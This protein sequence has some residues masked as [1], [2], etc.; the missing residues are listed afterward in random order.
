MQ[1]M[2]TSA[3]VGGKTAMSVL[4]A[5][6]SIAGTEMMPLQ[7]VGTKITLPIITSPTLP[8]DGNAINTSL[9]SQFSA[10]KI[11][12]DYGN[13]I[14]EIIQQQQSEQAS[15]VTSVGSNSKSSASLTQVSSSTALSSKMQQSSKSVVAEA[16]ESSTSVSCS[17]YSSTKKQEILSSSTRSLSSTESFQSIEKVLTSSTALIDD[18]EF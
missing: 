2:A 6:G 17:S 9:E 12:D 7:N 10:M 15:C 11:K 5:D 13:D 8:E 18:H 14:G 16:Q 4:G 1:Q 3:S